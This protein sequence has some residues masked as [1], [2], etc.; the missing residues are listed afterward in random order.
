MSRFSEIYAHLAENSIEH[1]LQDF[2]EFLTQKDYKTGIGSFF[3]DLINYTSLITDIDNMYELYRRFIVI[4]QRIFKD[5]IDLNVFDEL[6]DAI[7]MGFKE[8]DILRIAIKIAKIHSPGDCGAQFCKVTPLQK[9]VSDHICAESPVGVKGFDDETVEITEALR[10]DLHGNVITGFTNFW[11]VFFEG[12]NW[13]S[14]TS[15]IWE[16]YQQYELQ[17]QKNLKE[18]VHKATCL[19]EDMTKKQLCEWLVFFREKFLS[20]LVD[21]FADPLEKYPRLIREKKGSQ[22]RGQ[23]CCTTAKKQM[24][25]TRSVRQVDFLVKSVELSNIGPH[26]WKDVRALAEFTRRPSR[27]Q[28]TE[29]F[30]QL[31]R[32]V[33]NLYSTQPLRSLVHGFCLFKKDFE[34]WVFHRSGAYSSGLLSI[35][36]EK[37]KFIRAISSYAL[38]SDQEL[39]LDTTIK[40]INGR[41]FVRVEDKKLQEKMELEINPVPIFKSGKLAARGT[42]CYETVDKLSVVKYSWNRTPGKSE[43][44]FLKRARGVKGVIKYVASDKICKISDH[45]D[46]LDFIGAREWNMYGKDNYISK[47]VNNERSTM[48]SCL[49]DRELTRLIMAPRGRSLRSSQS[50]LEFLIG[51]RDAIAGHRRLYCKKKILHGDISDNNIILTNFR[52]TLEGQLI[53]LDQSIDVKQTPDVGGEKFLIGTMMFMAIERLEHAAKDRIYINRTYRHDLESFFYVFIVGCVAYERDEK[54]REVANIHYW[55]ERDVYENFVHKRSYMQN[56]ELE[57]LNQFSPSFVDL[58]DLAKELHK[59]LFGKLVKYFGTPVDHEPLYD[60]MIKAFNKIIDHIKGKIY[61]EVDNNICSL[62]SESY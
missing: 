5:Q 58:K 52:D 61:F 33:R 39:G 46:Q 37:E 59:L 60:G 13:S 15:R 8:H 38:M 2:R 35:I 24:K 6:K 55:S 44:K 56:F 51:I 42:T 10:D 54:S 25:D 9:N 7:M 40:H 47:V 22:L 4:T 36:G 28:R 30:L 21:P 14:Q 12:K 32:H 34:L 3:T 43:I 17:N 29:K 1:I 20:Q 41:F 49:R 23:Y 62:R 18:Y 27:K 31:S 48:T 26:D 53:D 19:K 57:I 11:E 45:L 16:C 50:I